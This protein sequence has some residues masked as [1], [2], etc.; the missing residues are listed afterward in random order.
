MGFA[1]DFDTK[2]RA[3][4]LVLSIF[5]HLFIVL[6]FAENSISSSI[7]YRFVLCQ[8]FSLKNNI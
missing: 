5:Q 2:L 3:C 7:L 1:I 4:S 6:D 8:A